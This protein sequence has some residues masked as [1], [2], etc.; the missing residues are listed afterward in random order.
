MHPVDNPRSLSARRRIFGI[1]LAAALAV[2]TVVAAGST[3][4]AT[5]LT[6]TLINVNSSN[7]SR[8]DLDAA[9]QL[10]GGQLTSTA[11]FPAGTGLNGQGSLSTLYNDTGNGS[12]LLTNVT[13]QSITFPGGST[14]IARNAVG[15]LSQ[16][17]NL[18]PNVGG[19][20]GSAPGNYGVNLSAPQNIAIPPID[21]G[22]LDPSLAGV[23]LE[24]GTLTSIDAKFALRDLVID[25]ESGSVPLSPFSTYPQTFDASQLDIGISGNADILLGVTVTQNG[26]VNYGAV[27]IALAALE[28]VLEGQGIDVTVTNNGY[29]FGTGTGSYTVGFG[30]GT[31]LPATMATN[32]DATPGT[33]EHIG[34]NLRLT[35]PVQFDVTPETLPAPL[36]MLLTAQLGLSGQ[37]IGQTPFV[38]VDVPEPASVVMAATGALA[39][40]ILAVRRRRRA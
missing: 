25:V 20:S 17:L 31:A 9:A 2:T 6:F 37:L 19:A 7:Q 4:T 11:Q 26:L 12:Q 13:Q 27:G 14:A 28:P 23:M 8:L 30:M 16:N 1:S 29:S 15:L 18:Q 32:D 21:L 36:D 33:L 35:V 5:P 22:L 40:G 10:A 38:A 3:A 34:G 39:I 24:L